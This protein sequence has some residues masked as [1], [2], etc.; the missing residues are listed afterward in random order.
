MYALDIE[1]YPNYFLAT[2]KKFGEEIYHEYEINLITG[3]DDFD[4]KLD[5]IKTLGSQ[6]CVTFNGRNFDLPILNCV[7]QMSVVTPRMLKHGDITPPDDKCK[8]AID[9]ADMIINQRVQGWMW[10]R[11]QLSKCGEVISVAKDY[12][13]NHI[14]IQ[15]PLPS[16]GV[17]LKLYG[18]RSGFPK[19]QEL[20]IEP[21]TELSY[22]ETQKLRMYCRN[23]V[24]LTEH[25]ARTIEN[26]L[27]I[28]SDLTKKYDTNMMSKSDAQCAEAI[29]RSYLQNK[30]VEVKKRATKVKPFKYKVPDWLYFESPVLHKL[31]DTIKDIEFKL[32]DK[33]AVT[34]PKELVEPILLNGETYKFGIGGLHSQEQMRITEPQD[35]Q[36][37]GEFDVG[38]MYPSIICEQKL[39]PLH[40]GPKFLDVY[41]KIRLE[42]LAAK[43]TDPVKAQMYKI[44][45]NGSYGKFGSKYSSLFSPELL[46]QTTITG[47]LSLLMLIEQ[48]EKAGGKV[49]SANTDGVNVLYDNSIKDDVFAVREWW[50]NRT[51]YQLDY[52][53]YKATYNRDVNSYIAIKGSGVKGKGFFAEPSLMKNPEHYIVTEAV[54]NYL[55]GQTSIED[56]VFNCTDFQKFISARTVRGGAI[57]DGESCGKVVRWYYSTKTNTAIHYQSN[58]NIVPKTLGAMPILD[59]PDEIPDDL[60]HQWYID[61]A[62]KWAGDLEF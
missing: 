5:E 17:S 60:D 56:T 8:R 54:T 19:L 11:G 46:I 36:S 58:H 29:I 26:T 49:V 6:T 23:D 51:T 20:P 42:R 34:L 61:V 57:K 41:N 38:S 21:N 2:F 30:G 45:L 27:S 24:A 9:M 1:V 16:V 55:N 13:K 39:Y 40:L 28:R 43:K 33:G 44:V 31:V 32:S 50:E 53:P 4:T 48:M 12:F 10:S 35:N 18:C 59:L 52:T 7:M 47:Q 22:Y 25:L 62:K 37:F 3:Q 14:D 15:E